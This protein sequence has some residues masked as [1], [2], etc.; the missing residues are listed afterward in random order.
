MP[1]GE[2]VREAYNAWI[3]T[4][5]AFD[6]VVDSRPVSG[7]QGRCHTSIPAST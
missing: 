1:E 7:G 2:T 5:G 6:G 3:K 4:G